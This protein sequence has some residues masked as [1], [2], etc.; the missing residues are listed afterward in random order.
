MMY[1]SMGHMTLDQTKPYEDG[2]WK[3]NRIELLHDAVTSIGHAEGPFHSV[4]LQ[5]GSS[6]DADIIIF[7]TGSQPGLVQLAWR[8]SSG[9]AG[10]C[11]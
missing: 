9:C 1:V 10:L 4:E 3:K 6:I 8:T 2:F 5:S 11:E 7:A